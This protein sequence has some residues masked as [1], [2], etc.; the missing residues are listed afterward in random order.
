MTG[1]K[2]E[3]V[4]PGY[5]RIGSFAYQAGPREPHSRLGLLRKVQHLIP[6]IQH[7]WG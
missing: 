3:G 1:P 4:L 7:Y 5:R 6:R 2:A